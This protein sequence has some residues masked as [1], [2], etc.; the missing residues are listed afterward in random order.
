MV[1]DLSIK[2]PV[3]NQFKTQAFNIQYLKV[4]TSKPEDTDE[5]ID[6]QSIYFWKPSAFTST[7]L[8][9]VDTSLAEAAQLNI[10]IKSDS[11]H[12]TACISLQL[13]RFD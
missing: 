6:L 2:S 9:L 5:Q 8:V 7:S 4:K 1:F 11:S 3:T 10:Y 12:R 13:V